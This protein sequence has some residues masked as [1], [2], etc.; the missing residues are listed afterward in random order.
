M[1]Y[2]VLSCELAKKLSTT[3][4]EKKLGRRIRYL[5]KKIIKVAHKNKFRATVWLPCDTMTKNI[6][7]KMFENGYN[8]VGLEYA[9]F[10]GKIIK[11]EISWDE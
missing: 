5:N 8:I 10:A 9:I 2:D 11:Y 7:K 4:N 6:V 3:F 1:K